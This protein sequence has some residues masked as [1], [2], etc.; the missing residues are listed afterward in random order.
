[1]TWTSGTLS[2]H[3][4]LREVIGVISNS[5][6]QVNLSL[7]RF[8]AISSAEW[9]TSGPPVWLEPTAAQVCHAKDRE[10]WNWR[11]DLHFKY[12]PES[13]G[14]AGNHPGFIGNLM[15]SAFFLGR[16]DFGA[17]WWKAV[18]F[19]CFSECGTYRVVLCRAE[20]SR[21][22]ASEFDLTT[23]NEKWLI[24][25]TAQSFIR[26]FRASFQQTSSKSPFLVQADLQEHK[27]LLFPKGFPP[28]A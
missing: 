24:I 3:Y 11:D 18:S 21:L 27:T 19:C 7:D 4:L 1:M 13:F 6:N 5:W 28:P 9:G 22:C 26:P 10:G 2:K 25:V 12:W 23:A 15:S 16:G 14:K 17:D 8:H 20:R